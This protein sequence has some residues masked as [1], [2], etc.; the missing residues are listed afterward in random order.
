MCQHKEGQ[1]QEQEGSGGPQNQTP[2]ARQL[3]LGR[4]ASL[5]L[6]QA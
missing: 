3:F 5:C 4:L 2:C 6:E 1:R